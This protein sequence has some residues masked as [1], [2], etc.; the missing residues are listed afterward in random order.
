MST[1]I[2]TIEWGKIYI[3]NDLLIPVHE[4]SIYFTHGAR[5]IPDGTNFIRVLRNK[6]REGEVAVHSSELSELTKKATNEDGEV[7]YVDRNTFP[8]ISAEDVNGRI[9]YFTSETACERKNFKFSFR[10]NRYAHADMS[11]FFGDDKVLR[12]HTHAERL[13][14]NKH[15]LKTFHNDSDVVLM[16]LEVE[17]VDYRYR[18]EGE[19]WQLL[20]E[21]AWSKEEDGSLGSD[22]YELVSPILPLFDSTRIKEAIAPVRNWIEGDSDERCGGH[23]TLS[24]KEK[25]T[26]DFLNSMKQFAP[27]LYALYP[28]RLDNRYCK[29]K[30]WGYY[31]RNSDKY[32]AFYPKDTPSTIGG[33]VEIRLFAR[34]RNTENLLWRIDLL[35][36]LVNDTSSLNQFAQRIGCPESSLYKHFSKQYSHEGIAKKLRL[37]DEYAKK[38]GTHRNGISPSVKKRINSTMSFVVFPEVI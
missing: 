19:A 5:V 17:K 11:S 8:Y 21:T 27:I 36:L 15:R 18:E 12:Y 33:R 34:V 28:K 25:S 9:I 24:H 10:L 7:V 23:I 26:H 20:T 31:E 1:N 14:A 37:I 35:Q 16:G 22:G 6:E 13:N 29:A 3:T 4:D 38:Y 32:S 2:N 30:S